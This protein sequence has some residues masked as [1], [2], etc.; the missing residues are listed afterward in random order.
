MPTLHVSRAGAAVIV[1]PSE[2]SMR[3]LAHSGA[4]KT[5]E[6]EIDESVME[7]ASRMRTQPSTSISFSTPLKTMRFSGL[8]S[9]CT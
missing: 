8:M 1:G 2:S 3:K 7:S 6:K 4:Q 5:G 9:R